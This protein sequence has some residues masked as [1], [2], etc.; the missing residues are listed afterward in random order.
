MFQ[1][2][3]A[4]MKFPAEWGTQSPRNLVYMSEFLCNCSYHLLSTEDRNIIF[5]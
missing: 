3:G 2:S 5:K 4:D 1:T